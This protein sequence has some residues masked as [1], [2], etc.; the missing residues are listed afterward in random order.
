MSEKDDR[1]VLSRI[2]GPLLGIVGAR[3]AMKGMKGAWRFAFKSEP[4]GEDEPRVGRR[5]AWVG[6]STAVV[7]MAAEFIKYI[8]GGRRTPKHAQE[9]SEEPSEGGPSSG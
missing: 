3:Y 6:I 4:P 5:I 9:R 2:A 1:S 8:A 7:G